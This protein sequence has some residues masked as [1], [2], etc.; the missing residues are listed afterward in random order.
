MPLQVDIT[1]DA[2]L[3]FVTTL[4]NS[5]AVI[6]SAGNAVASTI[7]AGDSTVQTAGVAVTPDGT[8]AYVTNFSQNNGV[9]FAI[10]AGTHNIH[11]RCVRTHSACLLRRMVRWRT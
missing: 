8:R 5:V 6:D 1:P 7:Q 10:D 11:A 4:T 9:V 2:K 3:A